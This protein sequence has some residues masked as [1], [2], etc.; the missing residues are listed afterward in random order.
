MTT[1]LLAIAAFVA[2]EGV[3]YSAHRW[4]MHGP[5]MVW[6]RSHHA[7]PTGRVERNDLFPL[8][9]AAVGV[10]LFALGAGPLPVL[11]GP[12][13]GVTAYGAAY[14]FVHDVVIHRRLPFPALRWR[15]LAWVRDA[16]RQHHLGGGEPYGMLLP[17]LRRPGAIR[18]SAGDPLD[19]ASRRST[20]PTRARL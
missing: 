1:T 9:F 8:C 16:H 12:A 11:W 18:Q 19:R 15:Y 6:H 7:P 17:L 4:L 14:A 3:S 13:I 5:G 10:G 20:R 2:M